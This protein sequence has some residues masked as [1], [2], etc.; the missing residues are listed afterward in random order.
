MSSAPGNPPAALLRPR[1][2]FNNWISATGAVVGVGALF[3]FTL[4]VWMDFTQGDRN[5][6]LGILTY[7]VAPAFLIAGLV[8]VFAGA[9]AQRRWAIRHAAVP[10]KWRLDFSDRRQRRNLVLFGGG[11]VVF[12]MLSAFGS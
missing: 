10:D 5:P 6:Y 11:A 2:H 4:L 7:L 1:S 9:W 3:S 8:C 12:V